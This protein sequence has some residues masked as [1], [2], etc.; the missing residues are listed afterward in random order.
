MIICLMGRRSMLLQ[1]HFRLLDTLYTA[2]KVKIGNNASY[3]SIN[4][5]QFKTK[6]VFGL[7]HDSCPSKSV[8]CITVI[9]SYCMEAIVH[10]VLPAELRS[11]K[12]L[13]PL[14]MLFM[15]WKTRLYF[16]GG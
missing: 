11:A 1:N 6:T 15:A 16:F 10:L 3:Q 7:T 8:P 5:W 12:D 2:V 13:L 14:G 9:S 4:L